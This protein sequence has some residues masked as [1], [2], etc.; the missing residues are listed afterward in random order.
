MNGFPL[1]RSI[2][3]SFLLSCVFLVSCGMLYA[4]NMKFVTLLSQPVGSFSRVEL[5][6]ETAPAEI[7][8]LNF[9]NSDAITGTISVEGDTTFPVDAENLLVRSAATLGGNVDRFVVGNGSGTI[10]VKNTANFRGGSLQVGTSA[11]S[12]ILVDDGS[13]TTGMAQFIYPSSLTTKIANFRTMEVNSTAVLS[14]PASGDTLSSSLSWEKF[15]DANDADAFI[16][17]NLAGSVTDDTEEDDD[18]GGIIDDKVCV[19]RS[20]PSGQTFDLT[21]CMCKLDFNFGGGT[22]IIKVCNGKKC[23]I[24]YALNTSTCTCEKLVNTNPCPGVTCT[25]GSINILTCKCVPYIIR[26]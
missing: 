1:G 21:T 24:G 6:D 18:D 22:P 16:L 9:C 15:T 11:P 10:S 8:H 26:N 23:T 20:C 12:R 4:E 17:T 3:K 25:K 5:L 14:N 19:I 2:M 7:F 13:A